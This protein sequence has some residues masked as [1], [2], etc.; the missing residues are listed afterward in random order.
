M[1]LTKPKTTRILPSE[2]RKVL[3]VAS[4]RKPIGQR[5]AKD[6]VG[7]L[8]DAG[9]ESIV[10]FDSTLKPE[11]FSDAQ[12]AISV[13]G[14]GTI[15]TTGHRLRG[16][17][18]PIL[19]INVGK[20]GFLAEFSVAEIRDWLAG[21][22]KLMMRVVPRVFL[23]CVVNRGSE[24]QVRYALNE[25][26]IQQGLMTRLL[27]IDM[28]VAEDHAIQYRCDGLIISTPGG[29]TAYNLS[30]GGPIAAPDVSAV[31]VA[32][33]A[34]HSLTDRP[35]VLS[36]TETLTFAMRSGHKE[37]ALVFDGHEKIDLT[38]ESTW[39]IQAAEQT[40]PLVSH[41]TQS[42]FHLLR[43]RLGW[44]EK[45]EYQKFPDHDV[46]DDPEKEP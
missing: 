30:A 31:I 38:E 21:K 35:V 9:I 15:L 43:N 22:R 3:V 7:W 27:L 41:G 17:G 42:F 11:A 12:L 45:P 2:L 6:L 36:G 24:R 33:L 10:D 8:D 39:T 32:P 18:L 23:R 13:G 26:T 5:V 29:S 37:M 19:G 34:P 44:G 16:T 4:P 20:I 14:D 28:W 25:V 40:C 46:S 1:D